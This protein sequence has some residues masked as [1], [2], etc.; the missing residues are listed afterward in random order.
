MKRKHGW[1]VLL[2]VAFCISAC[3]NQEQT[4]RTEPDDMPGIADGFQFVRGLGIC[5]PDFSVIYMLDQPEKAELANEYANVRLTDVFYQDNMT[6]VKLVLEDTSISV[7]PA[8][9]VELLLEN[10][11]NNQEKE[12]RGET[13]IWDDSYFCIDMDEK[14][15]GRSGLW[16][17]LNHDD[18]GGL[19][20][21]VEARLSPAGTESGYG[22]SSQATNMQ[23][24]EYED[25]W[26]GIV[27]A[28]MRLTEVPFT[29]GELAGSF[30]LKLNGFEE[31]FSFCLK[32][33]EQVTALN[34]LPGWTETEAFS[35]ISIGTYENQKLTV[36][37]YPVWEDGYLVSPVIAEASY[38]TAENSEE[39]SCPLYFDSGSSFPVSLFAGMYP[40]GMR[41]LSCQ[42]PEKGE[43]RDVKLVLKKLSVAT[44]EKSGIY[45]I[46]VPD[47][48]EK[49]DLNVEFQDGTLYLTEV[50]R[51]LDEIKTWDE[52]GNV[53]LKPGIRLSARCEAKTEGLHMGIVYGYKAEY[54][55]E[56][57][58][59]DRYGRGPVFPVFDT[60]EKPWYECEVKAFQVP[61][62]PDEKAAE[63][64]FWNPGY[65]TE[66][67]Y[68]LP[69]EFP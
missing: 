9:E 21:L 6:V 48:T 2:A 54:L 3:Q 44:E 41:L 19:S 32:A 60:T 1:W 69:V 40:S 18:P 66:E 8:D 28:E 14:I 36:S 26:H 12:E 24:K 22:F 53:I 25:G 61:Y 43:I 59:I 39:K 56:K 46:P 50:E 64:L 10:E 7:I 55:G 51:M 34:E 15:Y 30:E 20:R 16:E 17:A 52:N 13:V 47:T 33:A 68:V 63:I 11:R 42:I 35:S 49:L 5:R 37:W 45:Q 31:P 62:E 23:Y 57:G 27:T 58:E 67:A 65:F 38:H 29:K 4:D